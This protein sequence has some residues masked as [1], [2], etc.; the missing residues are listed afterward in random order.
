MPK[1]NDTIQQ[2]MQWM[3]TRLNTKST[4]SYSFQNAFFYL[5]WPD[6][7]T[8]SDEP[9]ESSLTTLRKTRRRAKLHP[10]KQ[11][12]KYI[13]RPEFVIEAGNHFVWEFVPGHG[14]LNVPSDAAILNH[15]R[16]CE[17]GGDDC[18][19]SA[20]VI[21]RTAYRYKKRLVE[22]VRAKWAELKTECFLPE[23]EDAQIKKRVVKKKSVDSIKVKTR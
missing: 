1:Y 12:S 17:F 20:S 22:R 15:Y 3:S 11:R 4:G 8:L 14:T 2:F 19:K 10:H 18:V 6:D 16:V 23:V 9:F 7:V 5:Q 21:D 13:C